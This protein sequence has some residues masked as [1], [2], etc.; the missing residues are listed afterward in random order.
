MTEIKVLSFSG[1]YAYLKQYLILKEK[2]PEYH[3]SIRNWPE[4]RY[5]AEWFADLEIFQ[6]P[7]IH[8][9]SETNTVEGGT[10]WKSPFSTIKVLLRKK[11]LFTHVLIYLQDG[12]KV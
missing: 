2:I 9:H 3:Y 11:Y 6:Y 7:E 10:E 8:G 1:K 5:H 4:V 12:Y